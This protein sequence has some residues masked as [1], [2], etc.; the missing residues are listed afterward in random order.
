MHLQGG[1]VEV[2]LIVL[3][4]LLLSLDLLGLFLHLDVRQVN[5]ELDVDALTELAATRASELEAVLLRLVISNGVLNNFDGDLHGEFLVAFDLVLDRDLDVLD[6]EVVLLLTVG[7]GEEAAFLPWPIGVVPGL[8]FNF[9]SL[10]WHGFKNLIMLAEDEGAESLPL[11]HSS[12]L[13]LTFVGL[14]SPLET[15]WALSVF[16]VLLPLV[17]HVCEDVLDV[18]FLDSHLLE[19]VVDVGHPASWAVLLF[20]LLLGLLHGLLAGFLGFLH[21][22]FEG[23]NV[24]FFD[25]GVDKEFLDFLLPHATAWA[26]AP[27][28]GTS[29]WAVGVRAGTLTGTASVGTTAVRTTS[30]RTASVRTAGT[31]HHLSHHLGEWMHGHLLLGLFFAEDGHHDSWVLGRS[32]DLQEGVLVTES[33]L[34]GRAVVEVLADRALESVSNDL[35]GVAAV[36][37]DVFVD[38]FAVY[39]LG[40]CAFDVLVLEDLHKDAWRLLIKLVPNEI[41]DGLTVHALVGLLVFLLLGT[42][43]VVAHFCVTN[44]GLQS[45]FLRQRLCGGTEL[46]KEL[47]A[48]VLF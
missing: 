5:A 43:F 32:F 45:L 25:S 30:V 1:L 19:D 22:F 26:S 9:N 3:S 34:A 47:D 8:D 37:G 31:S 13:T 38:N 46:D 35:L 39:G 15:E 12:A 21:L 24:L 2:D 20:L 41:F 42:V 40:L 14:V 4:R 18:F 33:L 29:L 11:S 44:D 7:E 6:V 10:A 28:S 48:L 27:R 23:R 17:L 16:L 36:A